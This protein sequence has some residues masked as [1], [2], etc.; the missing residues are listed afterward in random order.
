MTIPHDLRYSI[1]GLTRSPW[2]TTLAVLTLAIGIGLNTA[3]FSLIDAVVLRALP[4]HEPDRLVEIWGQ[5]SERTSMLVP[6]PFQEA[7]RARSTTLADIAMHGPDGGVLRTRDGAVDIRGDHV[8]ANYFDVLGVRPLAGRTFLPGEDDPAA[9]PVLVIAHQFWQRHLGGDPAAVGRTLYLDDLAYTVVGI[10]PPEF[11]TN[12][13]QG[14]SGDFW[15]THLSE[16]IRG[17][18]AEEGIELIGRLALGVKLETARRELQAIGASI[19]MEGWGPEQRR[20]GMVRLE[21][22][23][24]R[25]SANPLKLLLAAVVGVLAIICANLALLLLARSD[26]RITEFA[27]RKAL[28]APAAQLIRLAMVE[29]LLLSAAGGLAGVALAYALLPVMIALAPADIPRITEAAIDWRVLVFAVGLTLLTGCAF[30]IAPALRLSRLSVMA[31][32]KRSSGRS[33]AR[34]AGFRSALVTGQVAAS[35]ALFVLTGLVGRTFLTLL[36]SNPGFEPES[37]SVFALY[38]PTTM[39]TNAERPRRF[40]ELRSR[41]EVVPGVSAVGLAENVPFSTDHRELAVR[42]TDG[43][44]EATSDRRAISPNYFQLLQIPLQRGRVFTSADGADAP[45]VAIVNETLARK[46]ASSGDVLGRSVRIGG[47]QTAAPYQ[48][49][50]VVADARSLGESVQIL[51]EIYVPSAQSVTPFGFLIVRSPLSAKELTVLVRREI[52]AVA[53]ELPLMDSRSATPLTELVNQ[54]LAGPR[55]SAT[56][57]TAF[58]ATALLLAAI[59]VFGLVAYSVSQRKREFGTRAALGARP[60]DLALIAVRSAIVLTL[61]GVTVGLLAA[62]YLTRFV[63]EQLYAVEPLDPPTFI[64]AAVL[65]VLVAG[66]ASAIPARRAVRL[67]PMTALRSD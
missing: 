34:S 24:V 53:P 18:Q 28:G 55:F 65:M 37:I 31:A 10:M 3:L 11:R 45:R 58:S 27:T 40:E 25:D 61:T 26:L 30:G 7:L 14:P 5:E 23:I 8:S 13:R 1:R 50:G 46:L 20:L 12:F 62:A 39:Y 63:A 21:N 17:F 47:S 15:T 38:L 49:V 2:F 19:S 44:T 4:F 9:A 29:S 66:A 48:I 41:V 36:P 52:R 54:S 32:L 64:G 67:D 59:G 56:L 57:T 35:V 42:L 6:L 60:Q 22:E 33:S 43:S 16:Q 51:N